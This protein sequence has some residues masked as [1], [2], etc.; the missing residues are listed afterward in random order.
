MG[1]TDPYSLSSGP[2]REGKSWRAPGALTSCFQHVGLQNPQ[3][4]RVR[5]IVEKGTWES[6]RFPNPVTGIQES[7]LILESFSSCSE[8]NSDDSTTWLTPSFKR[9]PA[10]SGSGC[11]GKSQ[12]AQGTELRPSTYL[13][14][15]LPSHCASV[16]SFV[17]KGY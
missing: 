10:D 9:E 14:L 16:S 13:G 15:L 1:H 11:Q 7:R 12:T 8:K 17:K 3:D 6:G 5:L 4:E 2:G